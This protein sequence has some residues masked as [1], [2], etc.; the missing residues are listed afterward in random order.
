MKKALAILALALFL[1]G[2]SAPVIAASFDNATQI[3]LAEE[4]PKKE[5]KKAEKK[6]E[7]STEKSS[8]CSK[9][10]GG[11]KKSDCSKK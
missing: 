3:V 7:K 2:I 8:E 9:S 10:C 4:E 1:G 11:E 5:E 6:S